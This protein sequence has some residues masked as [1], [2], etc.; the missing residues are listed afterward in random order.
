MK[1]LFDVSLVGMSD[2]G[3]TYKGNRISLRELP[4]ILHDECSPYTTSDREGVV[5]YLSKREFDSLNN[6]KE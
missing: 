1:K 6:K 2:T 3:F 4:D 5:A